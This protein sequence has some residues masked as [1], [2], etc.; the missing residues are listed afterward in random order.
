MQILVVS[1]T[2]GDYTTFDRLVRSKPKAEVVIF[3]GDGADDFEIV[4]RSY[5]DKMF[6]GVKGNNDWSSSLPYRDVRPIGGKRFFITHGHTENVKYGLSG[7]KFLAREQKADV[8]LFGHT[9][10]PYYNYD[11]GLWIMNPGTLHRF[12]CS[13]GLIDIQNGQVLMNTAVFR[14]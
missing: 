11:D 10:I 5:P 13:Y 3:C 2:H 14:A 7:L 1:D 6:I 4:K 8:V 12:E 9:H